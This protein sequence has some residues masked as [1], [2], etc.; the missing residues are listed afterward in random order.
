MTLGLTLAQASVIVDEALKAARSAS[1]A[2][3]TVV[4]LDAGGHIVAVKKEDN[5]ST[6]RVEIARGKAAAALGMGRS[7]RDLEGMGTARPVFV[8]SIAAASD[9]RFVPAP[10]GVLVL[11]ANNTIIGAIGAS[12]DTSDADER[13]V[14]AGIRAAGLASYPAEP[15]PAE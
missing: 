4:A 1:L 5:S 3:I 14:I 15:Q 6:L 8:G 11:D 7:S 9:G 12:G 10:G 13:C 2:P